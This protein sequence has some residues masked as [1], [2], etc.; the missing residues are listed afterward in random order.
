[1]KV[2]SDL[3]C[4]IRKK[5]LRYSMRTG[6]L[7]EAKFKARVL[8]AG[9][10]MLFRRLRELTTMKLTDEQITEIPIFVD[11]ILILPVVID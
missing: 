1:M 3:Q 9:V 6:Y 10:Q 5:E 4:A 8:A 11:I 2:P 7:S